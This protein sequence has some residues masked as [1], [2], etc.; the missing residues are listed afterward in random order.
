MRL[1]LLNKEYQLS[2]IIL[3]SFP[4]MEKKQKIKPWLLADP[5]RPCE[6]K[7]RNSLRSNRRRFYAHFSLRVP[8]LRSLWHPYK[9]MYCSKTYES[10]YVEL[11]LIMHSSHNHDVAISILSHR[12][13]DT[14]SH[15]QT[16]LSQRQA[17]YQR[18]RF[19]GLA[20][21]FARWKRPILSYNRI[22]ACH[23]L[24]YC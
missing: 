10:G 5:L 3:F 4:L 16:I 9:Q 17:T 24:P 21:L 19:L 14:L 11:T 1:L 12:R 22:A 2:S 7:R 15:W 8:R 20:I 18:P 13:I 23:L 6:L